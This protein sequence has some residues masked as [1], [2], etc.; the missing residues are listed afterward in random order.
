[1]RRKARTPVDSKKVRTPIEDLEVPETDMQNVTGGRDELSG[2]KVPQES[3]DLT[4]IN[5]QQDLDQQSELVN[6]MSDASK[7][8][9]DLA[10]D[11]IRKIR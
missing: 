1:M 3:S 8:L 5:L 11:S 10:T 6:Q 4:S 2:T 9:H 7:T